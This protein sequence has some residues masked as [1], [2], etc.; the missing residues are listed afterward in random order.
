[1]SGRATTA[2]LQFFPRPVIDELLSPVT[3]EALRFRSIL[4]A[5][6]ASLSSCLR[7][8]SK[9][10]LVAESF[11]AVAL[12]AHLRASCRRCFERILITNGCADCF[13]ATAVT[14]GGT[15]ERTGRSQS[16]HW[17]NSKLPTEL[18]PWLQTRRLFQSLLSD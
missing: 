12:S 6:S 14:V 5:C 9:L 18:Q 2:G 1:M 7:S 17:D 15:D 10:A 13:A 4:S 16:A 11:A 8:A 3:G